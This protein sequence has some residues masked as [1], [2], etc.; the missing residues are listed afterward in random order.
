MKAAAAY[1]TSVIWHNELHSNFYESASQQNALVEANADA[2][3]PYLA[4]GGSDLIWMCTCHPSTN[5]QSATC[6]WKCVY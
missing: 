1:K 5:P 4:F 2:D 3:A 6:H